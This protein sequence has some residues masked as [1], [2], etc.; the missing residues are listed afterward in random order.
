[1]TSTREL[2]LRRLSRDYRTADS[3]AAFRAVMGEVRFGAAVSIGG[4]PTRAHPRLTNLNI[5][6]MQN[7]DLVGTAYQLP[8]KNG[9]LAALHCEA[10]LEHLE[11]PEDAAREMFR[12]LR[13]G[14]QLFAAT[15]FIQGFHGFPSHYQNFTLVG[16]R[17]L[18][19][20]AGFDVVAAGV[21]V[22]P[23]VAL[24]ELLAQY[25]R[26]LLPGH[27]FRRAVGRLTWLALLPVR[28]VDLVMNARSGA[29][30]VASTTYVRGVKPARD[31]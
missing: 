20:R 13:P 7:V 28:G 4:G 21:S 27:F 18:F 5:E 31:G 22:G 15:P 9:S 19:E 14:G 8:F 2:L 12:V 24:T 29:H 3:D 11:F 16:H 25:F 17:R 23:T 30:S 10:V 26:E 1:M 6:L